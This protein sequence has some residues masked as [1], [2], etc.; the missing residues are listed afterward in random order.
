MSIPSPPR[1]FT[2]SII[3]TPTTIDRVCELNVIEQ[4][5]NVSLTTIVRDAWQRGHELAVHGWIY[6]LRDGLIRDLG[7]SARRESDIE[8]QYEIAV[9]NLGARQSFS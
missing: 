9:K 2:G 7:F 4:V 6:R 3:A 5:R 8:D 1:S